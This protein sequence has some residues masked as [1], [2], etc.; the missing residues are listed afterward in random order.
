M[1]KFELIAAF[2]V[3][4]VIMLPITFAQQMSIQRFSGRDNVNGFAKSGD[5]LTAEV[6]LPGTVVAGQVRIFSGDAYFIFDSCAQQDAFSKCIYSTSLGELYGTEQ[7]KIKFFESP[8]SNTVLDEKPA[9]ITTDVIAPR[10]V[11]F[12]VEPEQS[13]EGRVQLQYVAEDRAFNPADASACSGLK[14]IVFTYGAQK[15]LSDAG[16]KSCRKENILPYEF[17]G[18]SSYESKDICVK[19]TD[20]LGQNSGLVCKKFR[21][22]KSAPDIQKIEISDTAGRKLSHLRTGQEKKASIVITIEGND[23]DVVFESV[24]ADLSKLNPSLGVKNAD[25]KSAGNKNYVWENVPITTPTDC[26]VDVSA[27]DAIGNIATKKL[28]CTLGIDNTPPIPKAITTG[29][30]DGDVQLLAGIGTITVD[31]EE[32]GAGMN[33][34][35]AF[36]NLEQL[37][38]GGRVKATKCEESGGLW[39]CYWNVQPTTA[40]AKTINVHSETEDDAGNRVAQDKLLRQAVSV[41]KEKP[42]ILGIEKIKL[43]HNNAELPDV[44]VAGD[45]AE[46]YLKVKGQ[47]YAFANFSDLNDAEKVE[48]EDC[49]DA[50]GGAYQVCKFVAIIQNSGPGQANLTFEFSDKAGNKALTKKPLFIYGVSTEANPNHWKLDN[51]LIKCSPELV[52]R[53]TASLYPHP[54]FCALTLEKKNRNS[55]AE[56][57]TTVLKDPASCRGDDPNL[58]SDVKIKNA[59]KSKKPVI[60]LT[61]EPADFAVNQLNISCPVAVYTK[62]GEMFVQEPE[63]ELANFSIKFYNLPF[64]EL[65]KNVDEDIED[66]VD[67]AD[68]FLKWVGT[69]EKFVGYA[70]KM[71][72][73]KSII[74]SILGTFDVILSV[75]DFTSKALMAIPLAQGAAEDVDNLRRNLCKTGKGPL[76]QWFTGGGDPT[77]TLDGLQGVFGFL[78]NACAFIECRLS[79]S[80]E[81]SDWSWLRDGAAFMSGGGLPGIN[82]CQ[83]TQDFLSLGTNSKMGNL[84]GDITTENIEAK[85]KGVTN[86]NPQL[87]DV[88]DSLVWSTACFC[89]PGILY[90]LNKLRQINCRYATCL[91]DDMKNKGIP[92]S[93]CSDTKHYQTCN[94]VM[95]EVFSLLPIMAFLDKIYKMLVDVMSNPF[96]AV[97]LVMGCICGGC[98]GVIPGVVD[99]CEGPMMGTLYTVC[100]TTKTIAKIG[101]ATASI[102]QLAKT[103]N[104]DYWKVNNDWCSQMEEAQ[105]RREEGK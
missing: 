64:G 3:L 98:K 78:D 38:L 40:G 58:I 51:N 6:T 88:K 21:I 86:N 41:D 92:K 56:P 42:I 74:S 16:E 8:N 82:W 81:K 19:A 84:F 67:S 61:L 87:I 15:I 45:T 77:K 76:E 91:M 60:S 57:V 11:D 49:T 35:N 94:F 72:Q 95:G 17:T 103:A 39:K 18:T 69:I 2:M 83:S 5:V 93:Y 27:S 28:T 96:A 1:K 34:S 80:K 12:T 33:K 26:S 53:S 52:D 23:N 75:M 89:V 66:A 105:E 54:V 70:G 7:Y 31:F 13:K 85:Y 48:A 101:D 55:K 32:S 29:F 104:A 9:T 30:V 65:S 68:G 20:M 102:M 100:I 14:E 47:D 10:I 59:G 36:L 43:V 4:L 79:S 25:R 99:Y 62:I 46:W 73:F 24:T 63:D 97:S 22:D 50:D 90:N 37:G 71:C 44:T